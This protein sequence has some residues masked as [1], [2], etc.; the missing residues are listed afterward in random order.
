[1]TDNVLVFE[2][3][4]LGLVYFPLN[5]LKRLQLYDGVKLHVGLEIL[6]VD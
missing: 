6:T 3:A 5:Q 1:M 2:H 4:Q